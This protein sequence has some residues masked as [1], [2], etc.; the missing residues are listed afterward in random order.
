MLEA[1]LRCAAGYDSVL[2]CVGLFQMMF[3]VVR[4]SDFHFR[5]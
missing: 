1:W 2:R 5:H 4:E 3:D